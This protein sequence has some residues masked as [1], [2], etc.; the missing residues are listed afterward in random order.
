MLVA[1]ADFRLAGDVAVDI[2]FHHTVQLG[3][4][5][6]QSRRLIVHHA[7]ILFLC[8]RGPAGSIG[9]TGCLYVRSSREAQAADT[10]AEQAGF[11]DFFPHNNDSFPSIWPGHF[12]SSIFP[13]HWLRLHYSN[14]PS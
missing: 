9:Q 14:R 2:F 6:F 8:R 1:A 4:G 3:V 11:D 12:L 10:Q 5:L 13:W 7:G